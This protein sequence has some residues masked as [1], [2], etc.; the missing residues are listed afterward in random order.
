MRLLPNPLIRLPDRAKD[1]K[2][3]EVVALKR[4]R[5]D[6]EKNGLP[7]SGLREITI[8]QSCHHPNVVKLHEVVVGRSLDSLFLN[9]EYCVHDLASLIDNNAKGFTEAQVKCIFQ[10]VVAGL[11]YLHDHFIIHRDLK[12]SNLLMND[13]GI[14]KIADFGL[15]RLYGA[16]AKPS[17]PQIV[18]LW[19]RAPEILLGAKTHDTAIDIWAMGCILGE[20]L[21]N[22]P[23]IPG[24]TEIQQIDMIVSL[25]GTPS[26]TIWSGFSQLPA[27]QNFSLK[28]QPYNYLKDKFPSLSTSGLDLLNDMFMYDPAKRVTANQCLKS[29]YL[30]E[31]PYR[32]FAIV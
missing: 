29:K 14:V 1:S 26:D 31:S 2:S 10:Q 6:N 17:T 3:G 9:L 27:V 22:R 8:L 23:L 32:K 12:V 4:V 16:T 18:T 20:L 25:L 19:Y 11:D 24:K 21:L 13:Q 5:M 15:A 28:Q 30:T 7:V